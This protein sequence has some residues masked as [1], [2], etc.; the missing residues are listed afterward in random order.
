MNT[1]R[2]PCIHGAKAAGRAAFTLVEVLLAISLLG[3]GLTAMLVAASRCIVVMKLARN[4]QTAQWT[5]GVAEMEHPLLNH[6]DIEDQEVG[7]ID[8]DGFTYARTVDEDDDEDGL[9]AVH[10]S[11]SWAR[12]ENREASERVVRYIYQPEKD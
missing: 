2:R 11:I 6:I 8:Y 1:K 12:G 5:L 10:M 7:P 4:Y 9:R 3:V